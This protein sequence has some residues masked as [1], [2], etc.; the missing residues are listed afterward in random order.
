MLTFQLDYPMFF[1]FV[2]CLC[3]RVILGIAMAFATLNKNAEQK[4]FLGASPVIYYNKHQ[5][6]YVLTT[7]CTG[8]TEPLS[9]RRQDTEP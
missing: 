8:S 7:N 6:E 1:Q 5:W 3:F 2:F 4:G 9:H